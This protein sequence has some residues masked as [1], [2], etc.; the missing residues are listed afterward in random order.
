MR[1]VW[2]F[3][4]AAGG[5]EA[6]E[7][8]AA[9][10]GLQGTSEAEPL[11]QHHGLTGSCRRHPASHMLWSNAET[12]KADSGWDPGTIIQLYVIRIAATYAQD[13][14]L[15]FSSSSDAHNLSHGCYHEQLMLDQIRVVL[16]AYG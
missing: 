11:L 1:F 10:P 15:Q 13:L 2:I 12:C 4:P 3:A 5:D 9:D 14:V 7:G 6:C 8:W 16:Q